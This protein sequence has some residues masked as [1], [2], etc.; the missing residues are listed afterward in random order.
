MFARLL[1]DL[2]FRIVV[3]PDDAFDPVDIT[4]AGYRFLVYPPYK[5]GIGPGNRDPI[6]GMP[7]TDVAH[8]L[9]PA[10]PQPTP[11]LLDDQPATVA[12]ALRVDIFG[13]ALTRSPGSGEVDVDEPA[14][15]LAFAVANRFLEFLRVVAAAPFVRPVQRELIYSHLRYLADDGS[16]LEHDPSLVRSRFVAHWHIPGMPLLRAD[17]RGASFATSPTTTSS[18]RGRPY[19]WMRGFCSNQS[20]CARRLDPRLSWPLLRSKPGLTVSCSKALNKLEVR[21][22]LSGP[23]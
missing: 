14:I 18:R 6:E 10:D 8:A 1:I 5:S 2:G 3:R 23:G 15:P 12:D 21:L 19:S 16:D 11:V 22:S 9:L 20:G 4:E 13:D 17:G 7:M